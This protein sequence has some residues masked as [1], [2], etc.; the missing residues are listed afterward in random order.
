MTKRS[1]YNPTTDEQFKEQI[2]AAIELKLLPH[3]V[4]GFSANKRA[5]VL[6]HNLTVQMNRWIEINRAEL[7]KLENNQQ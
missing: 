2:Q 1:A 6:T 3:E 5:K 4:S 7:K